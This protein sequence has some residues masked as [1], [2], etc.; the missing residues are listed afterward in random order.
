MVLLVLLP[1]HHLVYGRVC[2]LLA[3]R[4]LLHHPRWA[5]LPQAGAAAHWQQG[6]VCGAVGGACCYLDHTTQHAQPHWQEPE[7]SGVCCMRLNMCETHIRYR[8][9]SD[10]HEE[11]ET[12]HTFS[13]KVYSRDVRELLGRYVTWPTAAA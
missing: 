1:A 9:H 3:C 6:G 2:L 4:L 13:C 7:G 11:T 5:C 8:M 10:L 12:C